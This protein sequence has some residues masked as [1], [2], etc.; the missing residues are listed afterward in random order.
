LLQRGSAGVFNDFY[1]YWLAAK[2]LTAG[3]NPYDIGALAS[4]AAHAGIHYTAGTGYSYPILFAYLCMPLSALPAATASWVFCA[5]SLGGLWFAIALLA[6]PLAR[7]RMR[8]MILLSVMV[9]GFTP[10]AGSLYF[11]QANLLILPL[12]ALAYR[13]AYRPIALGLATAVKLYPAAAL[14]AIGAQG[15]RAAGLLAATVVTSAGLTVMPNLLSGKSPNPL[16]SGL[17][18]PDPFWTNQSINGWISRLSMPSEFTKPP[19]PGL[20]VVPVELTLVAL[21]GAAVLGVMLF[22]R[23]S[24]WAGCLALS[25]LYGIVAAPKNSLWNYTPVVLLLFYAWP[26]VRRRPELLATLVA[27]LA[28]VEVQAVVD[29]F[30]H[31]FYAVPQLTWLS[32][33]ALYGSLLLM[34]LNAYLLLSAADQMPDRVVEPDQAFVAA[35]ELG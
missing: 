4:T 29:Y 22:R 17:L 11:G 19:L 31:N 14:A 1:D 34:A 2:V 23:G 7:L 28:L 15:E 3:G 8:E 21:L 16:T 24:P 25:L 18:A 30:R 9:G 33:L 32:S 10:V 35:E 5:L 13:A 12:L 26:L 20:P 6:A 27:G